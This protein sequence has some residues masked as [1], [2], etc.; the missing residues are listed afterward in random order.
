MIVQNVNTSI[1]WS[2]LTIIV[3]LA[4]CIINVAYV[5]T[6]KRMALKNTY[7]IASAVMCW[8]IVLLNIMAFIS[9]DIILITSG[10][11]SRIGLIIL[12]VVHALDIL[13][14]WKAS[15]KERIL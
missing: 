11:L 6:H 2:V 5:I 4:T 13:G 8:Y 14:D 15:N 10:T 1:E 12:L 7:R 3:S 9:S